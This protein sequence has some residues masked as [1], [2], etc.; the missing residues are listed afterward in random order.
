MGW[1]EFS[2][3]PEQGRADRLWELGVGVGWQISPIEKETARVRRQAPL[4]KEMG[5]EEVGEVMAKRLRGRRGG[6]QEGKRKATSSGKKLSR[7]ALLNGLSWSTVKKHMRGTRASGIS[8]GIEHRLVTKDLEL[9]L[10]KEANQG[11]RCSQNHRRQC[12]Q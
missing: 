8:F 9:E 12:R 3:G 1:E 6:D 5:W 11:W 2:V 4:E 10:K 7:C